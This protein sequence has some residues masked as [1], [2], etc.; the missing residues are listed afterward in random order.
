M[1]ALAGKKRILVVAP[2]FPYP[3]IGGDRVRIFRISEQLSRHAN[4]TL[5]TLCE[6][7]EELNFTAPPDGVFEAI[8]R[9][10]LPRWRSMLNAALAVPFAVPLQLAYYR[11]S[12]F[13]A[14]FNSLVG[15]HDVVFAHLLRMAPYLRDAG[16]PV[17]MEMTD[18][19]SLN[20]A[21]RADISSP[22]S[23]MHYVFDLEKSRIAK[24]EFSARG[25]FDIVSLVSS[26]DAQYLYGS[27]LPD[28]V[29]VS[30]GGVDTLLFP[31]GRA[32]EGSR[33]VAFIGNMGY[34]PNADAVRWFATD[35]LPLMRTQGDFKLKVIGRIADGFRRE[36]N[37][38]PG[39]LVTG[40]V[41]RISDHVSDCYA[42]VC[43]IRMGAGVQ[44][45]LLEY[46]ALGLPTVTTSI[47]LEGV[48][49]IPG[50]H[51]LVAETPTQFA[52]ELLALWNDSGKNSRLA[53][54]GRAFVEAHH[55]WEA[56]LAPLISRT[57][58]LVDERT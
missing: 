42:A 32:T 12:A 16:R 36:L 19:I 49:A 33:C 45:K 50:Q 44:T 30:G 9:V 11:S 52:D 56:V 35:I 53:I 7:R 20:Y 13:A 43:P 47:G 3:V 14:M 24:R 25:Q 54:K 31:F 4:V 1:G 10:Y 39:I 38:I 18:A 48:K 41:D 22:L 58:A 51:L 21:R 28:N 5:L 26:I 34:S 2:R 29:V 6:S 27:P 15:Q 46:M 17:V 23:P 55:S 37:A 57:L 8:H 40:M